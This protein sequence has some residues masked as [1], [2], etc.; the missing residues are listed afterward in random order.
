MA[1]K[2][3]DVGSGSARIPFNQESHRLVFPMFARLG[4]VGAIIHPKGAVGH[5]VIIQEGWKISLPGS[6][7]HIRLPY[8]PLYRCWL[9][10]R[11][12]PLFVRTGLGGADPE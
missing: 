8:R 12:S 7:A 1:G 3:E 11:P 9:A 6:L 10:V 4:G 2:G 5:L